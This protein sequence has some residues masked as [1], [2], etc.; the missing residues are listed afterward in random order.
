LRRFLE[1]V[2]LIDD[3]VHGISVLLV[4]IA[5]VVGAIIGLLR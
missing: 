2:L 5:V 1:R 4:I 3:I